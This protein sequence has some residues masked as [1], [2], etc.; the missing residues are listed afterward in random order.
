M[1]SLSQKKKV[2][3]LETAVLAQNVPQVRA[4]FEQFGAFEFTARALGLAC[5]FVGA[6]MAAALIEQGVSFGFVSTPALKRNYHCAVAISTRHDV[7][8]EYE[9][10]LFP[11]HDVPGYAR[12]VLPDAE[13]RAVVRTLHACLPECLPDLLYLAYLYGDQPILDELESLGVRKMTAYCAGLISMKLMDAVS[14]WR[15]SEVR[16][17]AD[18]MDDGMLLRFL[19]CCMDSAGT[20]P[21]DF[22]SSDFYSWDGQFDTRC[23][24][25]TLFGFFAAHTN[26]R[27]RAKK[28]DLLYG[29]VDQNNAAGL[30]YALEQKWISRA[31]D[32]A[33][34][35]DYAQTKGDRAPALMAWLLEKQHQS[36]ARKDADE[37]L[38]LETKPLTAAE[39]KKHWSWV[40]QPDGT[41]ML[42]SWKGAEKD[43]VVPGQI[44][45]NAVTALAPTVFSPLA[46]RLT[47]PQEKAR[48]AIRS[49]E[50][51][52][53]VQA[54]PEKLLW[55]G[56]H[57][58]QALRRVV[59][60]EG[61]RQIGEAA[62]ENCAGLE[63]IALPESLA[64]IGCSAFRG[65][66]SLK[67][68]A[69]P[70]AV[71]VLSALTFE[72][73]GLETF[74]VPEH[75]TQLQSGV[76]SECRNL[77]SLALPEAFTVIP[78][79]LVS[80]CPQLTRFSFGKRVEKIGF[81]AFA[82]TGLRSAE[83]PD[84][85][86]EIGNMAFL[87]CT[88]LEQ[89][90]LPEG[91]Q[92]GSDVFAG[93]LKLA[94]AEGNIVVQGRLF[95][96]SGGR[97]TP[98]W[99]TE[100]IREVCAVRDD[101]PEI[102]YRPDETEPE[103]GALSALAAGDEIAFGR[104]PTGEDYRL[105]PLHW[106][107]LAVEDDRA[108]L[109]TRD[110]IISLH[111]SLKQTGIWKDCHARTLLNDGFYHAA[112]TEAE[113]QRIRTGMI[114]NPK[115]KKQRVDGGPDTKDAV[116]LLSWDE[117]EQYMPTDAE[118]RCGVTDYARTQHPH[119]RDTGFW[120]LR[121]PG[122][123]GWGSVAVSTDGSYIAAT[124]NHTGADYLRP[125]IW[126]Q[127]K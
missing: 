81:R 116:F 50:I 86:R 87:N 122:R 19:K 52:G 54:I 91:A 127:L 49:L 97:L 89:V 88:E 102:V 98:L 27:K 125:A 61:V 35:L 82:G 51:P 32:I 112:F 66:R 83:L 29:L 85:V 1:A 119:K 65:C 41:L 93:C 113:R 72:D 53:T 3:L 25:E 84:S 22:S 57:G 21:I 74:S 33:A 10:Y 78:D 105:Q 11:A 107:V 100:E 5:R 56:L 62:F 117:M 8:E 64:E 30:Q 99:L 106:R 23:C 67:E 58:R 104:F 39:A 36:G 59:L 55:C 12:S 92:L 13:R 94:D 109:V 73:C 90:T 24:S 42:T 69:L 18:E 79:D 17:A 38:S 75:V 120:L 60:G 118:R 126:L 103:A 45:K 95:G 63:E 4:L 101:L 15:Q 31:A 47:A 115:N 121:T 108:L 16:R 6:E 37:A 114:P 9:R 80:A 14:G 123:G 34:L 96:T 43:V 44:G 70:A 46:E 26:V 7:D 110:C 28:W 111:S 76:F 48:M 68:I 40:K 71:T 77:R 20:D 2:E 124:G